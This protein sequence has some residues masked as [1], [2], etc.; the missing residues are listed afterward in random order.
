MRRIYTIGAMFCKPI[1]RSVRFVAPTIDLESSNIDSQ[2]PIPN[3]ER[4][5][6]SITNAI[7]FSLAVKLYKPLDSVHASRSAAEGGTSEA[8]RIG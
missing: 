7:L 6:P 3:H 4:W 5:P 1:D 8:L 2:H